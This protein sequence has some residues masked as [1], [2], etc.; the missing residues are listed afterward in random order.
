MIFEPP[1]AE[2]AAASR[3]VFAS[4]PYMSRR[5]AAARGREDAE[6]DDALRH[7]AIDAERGAFMMSQLK[8]ICFEMTDCR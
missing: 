8:A 5:C 7:S 2:R 1:P 4:R 3:Q 6:S